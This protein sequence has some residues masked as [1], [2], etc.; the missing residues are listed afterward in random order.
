MEFSDVI[1]ALVGVVVS[2]IGGVVKF[3]VKDIRDLKS[4]MTTC[5]QEMPKE[6]VLKKDYDRQQ[7]KV[8]RKLDKILDILS[9][10]NK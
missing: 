6:Y 2:I 4:S 10:I 9:G 8:D 1:L 3:I 5:Q 7:D